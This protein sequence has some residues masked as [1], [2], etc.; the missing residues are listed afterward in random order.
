MSMDNFSVFFSHLK[1]SKEGGS[2]TYDF[3]LEHKGK[4]FGENW[5]Q[6]WHQFCQEN[7][8]LLAQ[9]FVSDDIF[10]QEMAEYF[11]ALRIGFENPNIYPPYSF[12]QIIEKK[13][14]EA[15]A[16]AQQMERRR[17]ELSL[18]HF[19]LLAQAAMKMQ[20]IGMDLSDYNLKL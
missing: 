3:L 19:G 2:S 1:H 7:P 15:V 11:Q 6:L 13:E 20:E 10:D 16:W 9:I 8:G 14:P 12:E 4:K 18:E 5:V 17:K